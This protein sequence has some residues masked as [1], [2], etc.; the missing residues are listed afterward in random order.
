[1]NVTG[2]TVVNPGYV[3]PGMVV[4]PGSNAALPLG[5]SSLLGTIRAIN[6]NAVTVASADGDPLTIQTTPNTKVVLNSRPSTLEDLLPSDRVKVRYDKS[7]KAQTLVA[8]RR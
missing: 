7:M 4:V 1:V 5:F 8:V 2:P 3:N 6:G